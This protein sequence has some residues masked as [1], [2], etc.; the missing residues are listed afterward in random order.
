MSVQRFTLNSSELNNTGFGLDGFSPAF[1][2]DSAVLDGTGKLD[3]ADFLTV[4]TA[5]TSLGGSTAS[6][7]AQIINPVSASAP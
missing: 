5:T 3:G 6:A 2:L 1:N 7:T 4:A